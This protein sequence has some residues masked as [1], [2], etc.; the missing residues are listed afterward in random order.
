MSAEK[1][2]DKLHTLRPA[3][4]WHEDHGPVLWWHIPI[5]EPPYVGYGPGA[6]ERNADGT[7][8]T[9]A[10][11]IERGFLTHWSPIPDVWQDRLPEVAAD[12]MGR[13]S[14]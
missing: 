8:T 5:E 13:L 11:L 9:C 12:D 14:S 1:L 4:E 10:R 7:L 3:D 6:G 2:I